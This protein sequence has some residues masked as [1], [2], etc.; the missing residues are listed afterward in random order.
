MKQDVHGFRVALMCFDHCFIG[1]KFTHA[2]LPP[3]PRAAAARQAGYAALLCCVTG[4][5]TRRSRATADAKSN[6][7]GFLPV[8]APLKQR[9]RRQGRRCSIGWS[10]ISL[11]KGQLIE[12][13][14][15][16][17]LGIS[18]LLFE[19]IPEN[20]TNERPYKEDLSTQRHWKAD[21]S[22]L[23]PLAKPVY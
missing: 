7:A 4:Q 18:Q 10:G 6:S 14:Y 23:K 2:G 5:Y 22:K 19:N 1:K 12:K 11:I 9:S 13:C 20:T 21:Y 8:S 3:F 15:I 16:S 17:K